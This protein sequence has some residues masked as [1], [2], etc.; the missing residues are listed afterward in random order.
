M[1]AASTHFKLG[2][3]TLLA[4]AA[5]VAVAFG[6]GWRGSSADMIA[7]HTYFDESVQGLEI[8][9]PVKFR[10]VPI[11]NVTSIRIAPDKKHVHVALSVHVDD[12]RAVG[13]V[14]A[15]PEARVSLSTQGI[16]G[17]KFLDIDLFDPKTNPPPVLSFEPA[18]PYV[19]ARP[20]L[21]KSV[22]DNLEDVTQ[23]LP[24]LVDIAIATLGRA[25][26]VLASFGNERLPESMTKAVANIDAAASDVRGLVRSFDR[27]QIPDKATSAIERLG[28]AVDSVNAVFEGIG[29]DGGLVESTQRATDSI[30]DLGQR[31]VG[32]ADRLDRTLR[33]LDDAAVAIRA[34]AQAIDRDP[35]MLIKGRAKAKKP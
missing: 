7:Y 14:A 12:A 28:A 10:G 23:R 3:L 34:L 4:L 29:G 32:S 9:S 6:L 35:E 27:A 11:G 21:L 5:V 20:S 15:P 19:P 18:E 22:A 33:D 25:S 1:S 13:L 24:E 31:A 17:V 30:G 16:T 26:A 2:I 8:G